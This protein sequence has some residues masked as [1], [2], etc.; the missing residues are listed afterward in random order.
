LPIEFAFPADDP[1]PTFFVTAGIFKDAPHANAAKLF[2][3]WYMAKEQQSRLGTYS[4]RTDIEPLA[5]LR[6]LSAYKIEAGYLQFVSD[7]KS[8]LELRRKFESYTGPIAN[9]GSVH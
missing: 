6:P 3:D 9:K 1:M 4:A 2:L 8:I 7:E 5:G